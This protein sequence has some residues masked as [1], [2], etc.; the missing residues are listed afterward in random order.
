M[1]LLI[2]TNVILRFL[3]QDNLELSAKAT[4]II[5]NKQTYCLDAVI[6]EVVY[7]LSGVYKM[8]RVEIADLLFK[9]FDNDIIGSENKPII[10]K[11]LSIFKETKMDF[12]DCLLIANHLVNHNPIFTFDKKANNYIKRQA[13]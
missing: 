2:D 8:D 3:L 13:T 5:I 7:V 9:I 4:E 6:C 10:L 11:T 12:V 1:S